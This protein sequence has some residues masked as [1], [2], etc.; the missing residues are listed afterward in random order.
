MPGNDLAS[1]VE[2]AFLAAKTSIL[3][4]R[5]LFATAKSTAERE[6]HRGLLG[7]EVRND[8]CA[9]FVLSERALK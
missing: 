1:I 6:F 7:E 8:L 4:P 3:T 2:A 5:H 9:T